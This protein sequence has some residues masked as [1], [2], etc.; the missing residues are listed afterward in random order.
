MTTS[1]KSPRAKTPLSL[2]DP[3]NSSGG[4]FLPERA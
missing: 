3:A 4:K 2:S 1:M